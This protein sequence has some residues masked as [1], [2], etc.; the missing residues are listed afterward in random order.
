[1]SWLIYSLD[2]ELIDPGM[3]D[4]C[5]LGV[6]CYFHCFCC[7]FAP[8]Q[9]KKQNN[10][11]KCDL[12]INWIGKL[13]NWPAPRKIVLI[14]PCPQPL[15]SPPSL[16]PPLKNQILRAALQIFYKMFNVFIIIFFVFLGGRMGRIFQVPRCWFY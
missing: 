4:D 16:S 7:V 9:K 8:P 10:Y 13:L 5:S 1:M 14:P 6:V 15:P 2:L 11:K 3:V 12:V